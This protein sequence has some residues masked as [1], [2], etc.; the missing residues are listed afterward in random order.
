LFANDRE[1]LEVWREVIREWLWQERRLTLKPKRQAV[2][3][4]TQPATYLGFRISRA[5]LM[6]GPKAKRRLKQRLR[7]ADLLGPGR[8]ARCL[9]SYRGVLLTWGYRTVVCVPRTYSV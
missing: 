9:L 4:T 7:N 1:Q 5:G 2:Q 3:S 6:P 8:L